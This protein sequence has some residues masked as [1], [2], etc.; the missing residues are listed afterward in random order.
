[1][2]STYLR[3]CGRYLERGA[4]AAP[5][6][7]ALLTKEMRTEQLR[8]LPVDALYEPLA[9]PVRDLTHRD[10]LFSVP[11]ENRFYIDVLGPMDAQ[12]VLCAGELRDEVWALLGRPNTRVWSVNDAHTGACRS[13]LCMERLP[14]D[15]A[16]DGYRVRALFVSEAEL[17]D[18]AYFETLVLTVMSLADLRRTPLRVGPTQTP[19]IRL[20]YAAAGFL[21]GAGD[22]LVR[23]PLAEIVSGDE[24][25]GVV[26]RQFDHHWSSHVAANL[27]SSTEAPPAPAPG[28]LG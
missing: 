8:R 17:E 23:L 3:E 2:T 9:S 1:M 11:D 16:A 13:A 19:L 24:N 6:T 14:E 4:Q 27:S 10:H 5:S 20:L 12:D 18:A 15:A 28:A 26:L 7:L 25:L 21:Q 22:E